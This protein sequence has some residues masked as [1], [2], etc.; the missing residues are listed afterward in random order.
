MLGAATGLRTTRVQVMLS[1]GVAQVFHMLP[2]RA[3]Q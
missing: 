1:C 3:L 2:Y